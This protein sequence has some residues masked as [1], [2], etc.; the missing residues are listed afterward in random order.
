VLLALT[1]AEALRKQPDGV[2]YVNDYA[3]AISF[4]SQEEF[5]QKA[6]ALLD[7]ADQTFRQFSFSL[8]ARP[9]L[10]GSFP[11]NPQVLDP[12]GVRAHGD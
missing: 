8:D 12:N 7:N 11:Q 9:R 2:S 10:H 1:L 6:S 4:E 3:W 5:Q